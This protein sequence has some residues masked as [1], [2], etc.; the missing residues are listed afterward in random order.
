MGFLHEGHLSL[1]DRC[2]DSADF[3]VM[4]IFVNPL[5]F[6]PSEDLDEYPRDLERDL[7]FAEERG[8]DLVFAPDDRELYPTEPTAVV[9]PKRLADRLC[10]LSR[11][12]HF[13]GVLTVVAKLLG[14]VQPDVSVFGQKDFQQAVLIRRMA[15]DLNI[16]GAIEVGPTVREA[17]GLAMSSRNAYLSAEERERALSLSRGLVAAVRAY[18]EGERDV[19]QLETQIRERMEAAGGVAV[20]YVSIVSADDLEPLS[21]ATDDAVA[22]VAARV[23]STRL[24]DNTY[25]ARPDA[26]LARL[27][28][29][30]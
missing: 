12:G 20:E 14:I 23:G 26:G 29:P 4:S 15:E 9:T 22:A 25:L 17:D 28:E 5:Q 27:A 8:V 24:I 1:V 3:I 10:G 21:R 30:D 6:G 13:E 19:R 18:R 16:P 2:R 7:A 11:P